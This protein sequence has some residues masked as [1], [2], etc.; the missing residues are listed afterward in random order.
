MPA[1]HDLDSR[2]SEFDPVLRSER[3]LMLDIEPFVDCPW[4]PDI[5]EDQRSA[6]C[7]QSR[8]RQRE[9]HDT[10]RIRRDTKGLAGRRIQPRGDVEGDDSRLPVRPFDQ[11]T[12]GVIPATAPP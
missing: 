7:L 6:Y 4:N 5:G 9:R 3:R 10:V 1:V 2:C 11:P 12:S 8:L